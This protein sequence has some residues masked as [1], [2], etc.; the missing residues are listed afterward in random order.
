M[1]SMLSKFPLTVEVKNVSNF[2][3]PYPE[4]VYLCKKK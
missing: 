2:L 1:L 3:M 4:L